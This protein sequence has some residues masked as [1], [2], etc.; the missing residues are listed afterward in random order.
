M[1]RYTLLAG[2]A[3]MLTASPA[4]AAHCPRDARTIEADLA[5][6]SLGA[7]EKAEITAL[8]DK[9]MAAHNSGSHREAQAI[10]ADAMHQLSDRM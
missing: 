8:K 7:A 5:K 9:G 4:L 1:I 6:S 10:L 2:V 3:L